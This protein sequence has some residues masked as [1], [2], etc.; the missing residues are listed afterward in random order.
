[1]RPFVIPAIDVLSG[2]AVRLRRG[3][4][5]DV[6][7]RAGTPVELARRL[8]RSRPRLLHLV[9]LDGARSGRVRPD[10]VAEVAAA[11]APVAL[12]AAGGIRTLADAKAVLAAGAARVVVGTAAFRGNGLE[13][14]ST[15]L[16]DRLVIAID[17]RAGR[18]A[19][20]GWERS[21]ALTPEDAACRCAAAGV[22]RLLCTA[23]E[24]DGMRDG[25]DLALLERVVACSGLPVLAAGGIGSE[26]DLDRLG[27]IG[28]EGAIVGRALL[29]GSLPEAAM[30]A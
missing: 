29:D 20:E 15:A 30:C 11:A 5:E 1:M 10:L 16:G 6:S 14:L 13:E 24:R 19:V 22:V 2:E 3:D 12:Q 21:L 18:V 25:P 4:F 27:A 26:G 9:D 28:V 7:L 23:V 8:V 17:V